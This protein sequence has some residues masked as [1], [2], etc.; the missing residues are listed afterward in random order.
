MIPFYL[1]FVWLLDSLLLY[2]VC[3]RLS[4]I[5]AFPLLVLHWILPDTPPAWPVDVEIEVDIYVASQ[6][7]GLHL[8]ANINILLF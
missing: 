3:C 5:A 2:I 6:F 7:S 8:C 1:G 4:F